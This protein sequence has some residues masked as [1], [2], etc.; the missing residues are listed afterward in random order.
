MVAVG[1]VDLVFVRIFRRVGADEKEVSTW[2]FERV[3]LIGLAK[4]LW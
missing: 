1:G 3:F 2:W 4:L